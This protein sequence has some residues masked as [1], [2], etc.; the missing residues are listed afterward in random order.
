MKEHF[1]QKIL[2][3]LSSPIANIFRRIYNKIKQL[4]RWDRG[5]FKKIQ[6]LGKEEIMIPI[7]TYATRSGDGY[8]YPILFLGALLHDFSSGLR[9]L[10]A[11]IAAF[12]LELPV[13][14]AIKNSTQRERPF[15]TLGEE[16]KRIQPPDEHSLPSGHTA[17][18]TI[19][20]ILFGY[21]HPLSLLFLFPWIF[22]LG[23]SRI[24]LGV[25][26]PTDV[27]AGF[28]LGIFSACF[29]LLLFH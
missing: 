23:F 13:Y 21:F 27:F 12:A 18:A 19:I 15:Q 9:L 20:L 11:G 14:R 4:N 16:K 1:L 17:A 6:G 24:Y 29:G 3:R 2:N 22:L 28:I 8:F 5:L 25:H 7:S 26:Y 10:G